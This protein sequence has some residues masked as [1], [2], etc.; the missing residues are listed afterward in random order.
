MAPHKQSHYGTKEEINTMSVS[1][2]KVA[3]F[4]LGQEVEVAASGWGL[5]PQMIGKRCIIRTVNCHS[6]RVTYKVEGLGKAG[7]DLVSN[8]IWEE[9]FK[10]VAI[11]PARTIQ[12]NLGSVPAPVPSSFQVSEIDTLLAS[13]N[14]VSRTRTQEQA[15]KTFNTMRTRAIQSRNGEDVSDTL[16]YTGYGICDNIH[17]CTPNGANSDT[18]ALIKDNLIRRVP[19]YSGN[20]H[21]PV[22]CPNEAGGNAAENAWGR[23]SNRW[24][25]AYGT[26]RLIQLEELIYKIEHEWDEKFAEDMTPAQRV[27]LILNVSVVQYRDGTMWKFVVDDKS[28]DPYFEPVCGGD[29]RSLDLRYLTI[30]PMEDFTNDQRSVA[31]FLEQIKATQTLKTDLESKLAALQKEIAEAGRHIAMLDYGLGIVHKVKRM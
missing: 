12:I 15:L 6:D 28:S 26:N 29:R 23:S 31:Q 9:S 7:T 14:V 8:D 3:K 19:S 22:P 13:L 11:M 17:R 25:D 4:T 24:T 10:A 2:T 30:M 27:G 5:A 1:L 21:Y 16:F 18:M 20:Y